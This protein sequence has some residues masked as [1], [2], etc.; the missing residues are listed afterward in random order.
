MQQSDNPRRFLLILARCAAA[1]V[2]AWGVPVILGWIL[3]DSWLRGGFSPGGITVKTN[4]GIA[5]LCCG[6]SLGIQ[7]FAVPRSLLRL[8]QA[9]ALVAL[10]LGGLTLAEHIFGWDLGIDQLIFKEPAGQVATVSPNRMGP[11][12]SISFLLSGL[13]VVLL[14]S[15]GIR[16]NPKRDLATPLAAAVICIATISTLG[17]LYG[18][19]ALYGIAKYTG[20]SLPTALAF[21]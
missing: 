4:A 13:A 17:Y 8:A 19:T 3:D 5:F 12:A 16:E 21:I 11:P 7:C 20:I 18:A 9:L 15:S 14:G 1:V 10:L 2:A 6:V